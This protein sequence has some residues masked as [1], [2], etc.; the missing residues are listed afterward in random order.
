MKPSWWNLLKPTLNSNHRQGLAAGLN[1]NSVNLFIEKPPGVCYIYRMNELSQAYADWPINEGSI[2][3][4]NCG[5]TPPNRHVVQTM[6]TYHE[7]LG[8]DGVINNTFSFTGIKRSIQKMLSQLLHAAIDDIALIHNTSEG[9]NFISRG[10]DLH[11]GENII[12]LEDE[13]PAN[14]YPWEHWQD[15]GVELRRASSADG[16]DAFLEELEGLVDG[17][18]RVIAVSA[19]HWCT[20]MMLPLESVSELCKRHNILFVLDSAQGAGHVPIDVENLDCVTAF[21]C[22]KW[23]TGPTGLG[24]MIVPKSKLRQLSPVFKGTDSVV[25]PGNYFPYK[26]GYI[27]SAQRYTFS[28]PNF[29]DWVYFEKSLEYFYNTGFTTVMERIY[30]LADYLSGLLIEAGFNVL[31]T[32]WPGMRT[33]II[34]A[35]HSAM[36]SKVIVHKLAEQNITVRERLGAVRFAPHIYNA[37]HQLEKVARAAGEIIKGR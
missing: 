10:L 21:S 6:R 8:R 25:S 12:L 14:V 31:G 19:V 2:F 28:T 23:L 22:W 37:E 36:S 3:L 15:K 20:G 17:K 29:A 7:V 4:N 30:E 32:K 11:A 9:I 24:V 33:G 34:C 1:T 18:T 27:D 16:P 26:K 35:R 5:T 13:Y